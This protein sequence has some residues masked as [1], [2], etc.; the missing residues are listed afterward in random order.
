MRTP[1]QH[2]HYAYDVVVDHG[3]GHEID[4]YRRLIAG[5][6]IESTSAP[7]LTPDTGGRPTARRAVRRAAPLAG[8]RELR[9]ALLAGRPAGGPS[10]RR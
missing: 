6:G 3:T 7:S 5:A 2:R 1:G 8:R 4:N 9:G 10:P